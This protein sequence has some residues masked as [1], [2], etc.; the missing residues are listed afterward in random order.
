MPGL[1]EASIPERMGVP[2]APGK[3]PDEPRERD[4]AGAGG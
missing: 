4:P 1:M 3:Y 2:V